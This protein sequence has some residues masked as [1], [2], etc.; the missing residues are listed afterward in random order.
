M[1]PPNVAAKTGD[2]A[3]NTSL[4]ARKERPPQV[5]S[6]SQKERA[7]DYSAARAAHA[8]TEAGEQKLLLCE[9]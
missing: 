8:K 9:G 7:C 4:C 6:A 5:S 3:A 2:A 1:Q